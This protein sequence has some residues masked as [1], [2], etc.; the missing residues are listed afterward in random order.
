MSAFHF[1]SMTFSMRDV[2]RFTPAEV[3]ELK[4]RSDDVTEGNVAV[5]TLTEEHS[6]EKV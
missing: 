3:A 4:H 2:N 1:R 5:H 6:P